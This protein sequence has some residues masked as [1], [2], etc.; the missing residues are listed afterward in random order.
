MA[1]LVGSLAVTAL[2]TFG[3]L[4][5]PRFV[6]RSGP[7]YGSFATIVGLFALLYLVSQV[8]VYAAEIAVVRRRRLWPRSFNLLDPTD[9]DRRALRLLAR[10]QERTV[11]ERVHARFDA[12]PSNRIDAP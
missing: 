7:V 2:L 10:E 8:I 5:L 12:E 4:V 9:A 1:A 6:A 3:A 11:I